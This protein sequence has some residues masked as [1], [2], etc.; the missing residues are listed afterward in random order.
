MEKVKICKKLSKLK[1]IECSDMECRCL[2][3]KEFVAV[4]DILR[5]LHLANS[6]NDII[7][8]LINSLSNENK[9]EDD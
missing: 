2:E 4:D 7:N 9:K 3:S 1:H 6:D 8:I 5:V